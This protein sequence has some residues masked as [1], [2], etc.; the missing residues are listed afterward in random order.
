MRKKF[1][2]LLTTGLC[3][4]NMPSTGSI[5]LH[6]Q[7]PAASR[8][9]Q[10]LQETTVVNFAGGEGQT[11]ILSETGSIDEQPA[12]PDKIVTLAPGD[13]ATIQVSSL[14][15]AVGKTI[16]FRLHWTEVTERK[17][18]CKTIKTRA[19]KSR[20]FDL[21][22]DVDLGK[23]IKVILFQ[24]PGAQKQ[25]VLLEPEQTKVLRVA[26]VS[27][28]N[29]KLAATCDDIVFTKRRLNAD[30]VKQQ[31]QPLLDELRR[32]N[33]ENPYLDPDEQYALPGNIVEL[34]VSI[35]CRR[36]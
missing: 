15:T 9:V 24:E 25:E 34:E 11:Q 20:D 31:V 18:S 12:R 17:E 4:L 27:T 8:L 23:S 10:A 7:T 14:A 6:A 21:P 16:H 19:P 30:E 22:V 28:L 35:A 33:V 36:G 5:S 1:Q 13:T 2:R 3:A 29:T 26:V 32:A